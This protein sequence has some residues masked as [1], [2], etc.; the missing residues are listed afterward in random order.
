M[1]TDIWVST[2]E[3]R[4]GDG[5]IQNAGLAGQVE[6]FEALGHGYHQYRR[7]GRRATPDYAKASTL[8]P[9]PGGSEQVRNTC[10][11]HLSGAKVGSG[12]QSC[13]VEV[14][15]ARAFEDKACEAGV[16]QVDTSQTAFR[17]A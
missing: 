4:V 6:K 5:R 8:P 9:D 14:L 16:I 13:K 12:R 11:T 3:P 17:L 2:K 1:H 7:L 15:V 10:L